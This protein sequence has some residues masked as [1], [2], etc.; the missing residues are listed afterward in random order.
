MKRY[1]LFLLLGL[2]ILAL[3]VGVGTVLASPK[4]APAQEVSTLHPIFTLL[5]ANGVNVL[6]SKSAISTMK[7]CGQCHNT[8]FIQGHAFHSDLGLTDYKASSQ[9]W[10]AST[11]IFGKWDQLA[12]R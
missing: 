5:D 11:G 12:Y 10:D 9:T 4:P 7:T 1:T 8:E 6:E 3:A 2:I